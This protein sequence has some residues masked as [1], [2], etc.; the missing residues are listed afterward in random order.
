M[1]SGDM[2]GGIVFTFKMIMVGVSLA[3]G[4][5]MALL[6][7]MAWLH[8]LMD[9]TSYTAH[10][11]KRHRRREQYFPIGEVKDKRLKVLSQQKEAK[12]SSVGSSAPSEWK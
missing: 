7:R 10:Y 9:L 1:W 8:P 6:P 2:E 4:V 12:R 11:S 5:F 3:I